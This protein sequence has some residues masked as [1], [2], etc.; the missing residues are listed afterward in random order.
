MVVFEV[1]RESGARCRHGGKGHAS[2]LALAVRTVERRAQVFSGQVDAHAR[3]TPGSVA[4]QMH[5]A[6]TVAV[7][8]NREG[9]E[10]ITLRRLGDQVDQTTGRRHTGLQTGYAL[11]DLDSLFV[12]QSKRCVVGNRQAIAQEIVALVQQEPSY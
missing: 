7:G 4:V 10:G 3:S 12:L 6:T 2:E 5:L 11:Q 8:A 9:G 1:G